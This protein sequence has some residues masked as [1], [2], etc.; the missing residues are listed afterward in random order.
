MLSYADV[1]KRSLSSKD[2]PVAKPDD[3]AI[4]A[5]QHIRGGG[6]KDS[7]SVGEQ[8]CPPPRN[9]SVRATLSSRNRKLSDR[10]ATSG[11]SGGRYDARAR[12]SSM[13]P[14]EQDGK[15]MKSICIEVL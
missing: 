5:G 12:Q 1:V 4:Q 9:L 7:D 13:T 3:S 14:S 11:D 2:K 15:N 10:T 6:D 8:P